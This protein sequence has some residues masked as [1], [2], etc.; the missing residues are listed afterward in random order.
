MDST[1]DDDREDSGVMQ[2]GSITH[3]PDGAAPNSDVEGDI[4]SD[5]WYTETKVTTTSGI[6][7]GGEDTVTQHAGEEEEV[8]CDPS[9]DNEGGTDGDVLLLRE[10]NR[11]KRQQQQERLA[12][13]KSKVSRDWA[14]TTKNWD[15]LTS[16]EMEAL[17]LDEEALKKLLVDGWDFDSL[18]HPTRTEAYPGL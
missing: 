3:S 18:T 12:A 2:A 14:T 6:C 7:G 8:D 13:A 5:D 10:K 11:G 4:E 15:A 9:E 17:A 16:V 1:A